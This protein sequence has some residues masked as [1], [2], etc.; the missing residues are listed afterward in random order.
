MPMTVRPCVL[1]KRTFV[2]LGELDKARAPTCL[3][4]SM[5]R[6][7]AISP[8]FRAAALIVHKLEQVRK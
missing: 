1:S 2:I 3:E 5:V 7:V 6:V 4:R 8:A